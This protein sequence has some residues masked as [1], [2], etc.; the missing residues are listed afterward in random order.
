MVP[1][2]AVN[3]TVSPVFT[4]KSVRNDSLNGAGMVPMEGSDHA[5]TWCSVSVKV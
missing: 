2:N 4:A 1:P 5:A 3:V